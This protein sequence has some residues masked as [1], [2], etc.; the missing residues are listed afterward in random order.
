MRPAGMPTTSN[1]VAQE[2]GTLSVHGVSPSC[3]PYEVE[4]TDITRAACWEYYLRYAKYRRLSMGPL[5][6]VGNLALGRGKRVS[7]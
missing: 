2:D 5:N 7:I 6:G 4:I 3:V 1:F